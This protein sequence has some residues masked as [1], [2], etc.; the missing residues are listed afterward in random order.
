MH[1]PGTNGSDFLYTK[2]LKSFEALIVVGTGFKGGQ[3]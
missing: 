2:Q 1:R 3:F